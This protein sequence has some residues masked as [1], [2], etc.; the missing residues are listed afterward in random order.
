[1]RAAG[2]PVPHCLPWPSRC[3]WVAQR[4]HDRD[5]DGHRASRSPRSAD[6][7]VPDRHR[8]IIYR[9]A[10]RYLMVVVDHDTG[11]MVWAGEDRTASTNRR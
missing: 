7:A 5:Q 9:K 4:V 2:G 6:R 10:Q 1:M 11:R 8:E 3:A